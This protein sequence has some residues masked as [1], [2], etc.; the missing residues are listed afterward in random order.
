MENPSHSVP[1]QIK[2]RRKRNNQNHGKRRKQT[3]EKGPG[4]K[5]SVEVGTGK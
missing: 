3:E 1:L 5:T 4:G 2:E